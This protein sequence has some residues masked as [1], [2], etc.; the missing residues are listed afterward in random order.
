MPKRN[1]WVIWE[2]NFVPPCCF[3]R[4]W[5]RWR[6]HQRRMRVPF[7][8][9][10]SQS[11]EIAPRI[12]DMCHSRWGKV[13]SHCGLEVDFPNNN[14]CWALYRVHGG[15]LLVSSECL[16]TSLPRFLMGLLDF[17]VVDLICRS[18]ISILYLICWMHKVLPFTWLFQFFLSVLTHFFLSCRR[19]WIWCNSICLFLSVLPLSIALHHWRQFCSPDLRVSCLCFPQCIL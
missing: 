9:T 16:F 3:P 6:S 4:S 13:I 14:S 5:T 8:F 2:L 11:T 12:F 19:S 1:C 7:C 18:W 15:L 17:V 10:T